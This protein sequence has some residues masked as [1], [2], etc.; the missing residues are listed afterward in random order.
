MSKSTIYIG[1]S[2]KNGLLKQNTIFK[3]GIIP[4]H[5]SQLVNSNDAL[6]GLIVSVDDLQEARASMQKKGTILNLFA[7][8]V[9]KEI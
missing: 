6:R 7:R 2:L 5:L 1:Q 8:R 4:A 9:R 3:D